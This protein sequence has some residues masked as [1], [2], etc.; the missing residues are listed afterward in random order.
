MNLIDNMQNQR[1]VTC[2]GLWGRGKNQGAKGEWD[3]TV[4]FPWIW[5]F[6]DLIFNFED[7]FKTP[8]YINNG[9]K[10]IVEVAKY[11]G[12]SINYKLEGCGFLSHICHHCL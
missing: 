10:S 5:I 1:V 12:N 2:I 7:K 9:L 8:G 4:T 11:I 6:V 3:R